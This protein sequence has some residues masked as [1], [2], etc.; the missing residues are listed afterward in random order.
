MIN[1]IAI[2]TLL[3]LFLSTTALASTN[4][5]AQQIRSHGSKAAANYEYINRIATPT[6][7][8]ERANISAP[9]QL[10]QQL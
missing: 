5:C 7:N 6:G 10:S 4:D 2:A 3:G 9:R 8:H 1:N